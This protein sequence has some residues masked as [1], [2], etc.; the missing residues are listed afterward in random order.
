M[1]FEQQLWGVAATLHP[2]RGGV[3]RGREGFAFGAWWQLWWPLCDH[4][5]CTRHCRRHGWDAVGG[6]TSQL[7]GPAAE[8]G[9]LAKPVKGVKK[10]LYTYLK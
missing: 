1:P 5:P 4:S 10:G 8:A 9:E 6:G 3:V 2:G 7:W